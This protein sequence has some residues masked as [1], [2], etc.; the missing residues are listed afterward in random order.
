M[1]VIHAA[2]SGR[3]LLF[4]KISALF[5]VYQIKLPQFVYKKKYPAQTNGKR[6]EPL[7]FIV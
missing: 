4:E 3:T 1:Y 6:R 2:S 7:Y 5:G